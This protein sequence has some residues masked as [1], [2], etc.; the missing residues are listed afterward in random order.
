MSIGMASRLVTFFTVENWKAVISLINDESVK[1]LGSFNG[2]CLRA[3]RIS[4]K[5]ALSSIN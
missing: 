2:A 4:N 3:E 1:K 5:I